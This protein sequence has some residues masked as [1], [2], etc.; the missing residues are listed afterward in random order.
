MVTEVKCASKFA[1]RNEVLVCLSVW[2]GEALSVSELSKYCPS[3]TQD[4]L[5]QRLGWWYKRG[6]LSRRRQSRSRDNRCL[7]HYRIT[8]RGREFL[9]RLPSASLKEAEASLR[10]A[11]L[12]WLLPPC[13]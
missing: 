7:F 11:G 12:G 13:E 8:D 10:V 1:V 3:A 2:P 9:G 6:L 4:Y 5:E